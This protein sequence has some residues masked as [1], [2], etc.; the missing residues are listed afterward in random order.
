MKQSPS[1]YIIAQS[2]K[3]HACIRFTEEDAAGLHMPHADP[4]VVHAH[5]GINMV[6][7]I[8]VDT[9]ASVDVLFYDAFDGAEWRQK[10]PRSAVPI[11]A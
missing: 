1:V 10:R 5:L 11:L 6:K 3:K 4:L 2:S 7:R 8:L 9:G